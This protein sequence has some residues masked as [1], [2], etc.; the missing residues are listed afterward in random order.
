MPIRM[1]NLDDRDWRQLRDEA[2]RRIP[3]HN[4]E[5]T[6][7]NAS[8]PGVTIIEIF[9]FLTENLLYRSNLIPERNRLKF[10]SLLG[11]PLHPG[12]AAQGLVSVENAKGPTETI[13]LNSHLQVQ[14]G[15][16]PYTTTKGLDVLPLEAKI[17]TK[18]EIANP[19]PALTTYYSRL[20]ASYM[21]A[22]ADAITP[23]SPKIYETLLFQPDAT[24][25]L[26]PPDGTGELTTV[27]TTDN[28]IWVALFTRPDDAANL[29]QV[30]DKIKGKT[31]NLGFVPIPDKLG[32]RVPPGGAVTTAESTPLQYHIPKIPADGTLPDFTTGKRRPQ[33]AALPSLTDSNVRQNPGIVQVTLPDNVNQLRLWTNMDPLEA[34]VGDFPPALDDDNLSRRL[35]TWLRISSPTGAALRFFWLGLN[36]VP[37][38]QRTQVRN[39]LLPN[40]SGEPDQVRYLAQTPVIPGSLSLT[41][42]LPD[43]TTQLW[44]A[45]DDLLNAGPEAPTLSPLEPPGTPLPL[46]KPSRVFVVD[47]ESGRLQFGDGHFGTRLPVATVRANYDVN[48]G[49]AGNVAAGAISTSPSLPPGMRVSNPVAAWGA[50]D[51]ETAVSGEKHITFQLQNQDRCTNIH[52]FKTLAARVSG[53]GRVEVLPAFNPVLSQN[54]PGDAPGAVTVMIIPTFDSQ[55]P[56]AP[57]PSQK[58]LDAVCAYLEPRRL[59]TTELFLRPPTY[60]NIWVSVGIQTLSGVGVAPVIRDVR[61]AIEQFLSPLPVNNAVQLP[62]QQTLFAEDQF[63]DMHQG[64]PLRKPVARLELQA[65]ANRVAGVKFVN[66]L[67]LYDSAGTLVDETPMRGLELP[68]LAG[69]VVSVGD[70]PDK[71]QIPS[72]TTPST[73]VAESPSPF[74]PVPRSPEDC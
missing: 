73:S 18:R 61:L 9:A 41:V 1:P 51:P 62:P 31:L 52:S 19:P 39:E 21:D 60:R 57:V 63:S 74:V 16:I 13:T 15:P 47:Y 48:A 20:Y 24:G 17:Y 72:I 26:R 8:D 28:A 70:A 66:N 38:T 40:G 4:P 12:S 3:V 67:D 30:R 55:N 10:L 11:I 22:G 59:V 23:E 2:L 42:T 56:N 65:V 53:V 68:R 71:D 34:G 44:Q 69:I 14:A 50:S 7:F 58:L 36:T 46:P 43:G 54:E 45:I 27:G 29:A 64:Y 5:W 32:R 33:Y 6:N 35:I 49:Q 25:K 37:V